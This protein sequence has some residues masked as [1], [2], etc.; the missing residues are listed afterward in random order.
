MPP[1]PLSA[2]CSRSCLRLLGHALLAPRLRGRSQAQ[3]PAARCS[4]SCLDLPDPLVERNR[5]KH[6]EA[7]CEALPDDLHTGQL[8]AVTE[9]TDDEGTDQGAQHTTATTEQARTA[10]HHRRKRD[11]GVLGGG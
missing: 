10:G 7:D 11:G 9:D 3:P 1:G 6:E 8:K 4:R 2:R 5:N